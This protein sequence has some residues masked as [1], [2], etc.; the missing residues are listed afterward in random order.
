MGLRNSYLQH[1]HRQAGLLIWTALLSLLWAGASQGETVTLSWE[2]ATQNTDGSA[3][4]DADFTRLYYSECE[5]G[6]VPASPLIQLAP[7]PDTS[8][9]TDLGVGEWC[10]RA[11][12]VNQAGEESDRSNLATFT[13]TQ[14]DPPG[15][16]VVTEQ[17]A[18]AISQSNDRLVLYPV[19][20]IPVG[21]PCDS[22]MSVNG[23]CRVDRDQVTL[24]GTVDP[25]VVLAECGP[26]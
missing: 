4:D 5:A 8:I 11:T 20:T 26:Q 16:L 6:D 14:P 21:T 13:V 19:G 23:K 9:S 12:H 3:Y 17:T 18:Y 1:P 10:F 15:S 24:A 2:K 25:A 7:D 22:T